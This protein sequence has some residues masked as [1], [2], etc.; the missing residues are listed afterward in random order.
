M[1]SR[2]RVQA[3]LHHGYWEDVGTIRSYYDANIALTQTQP[4][5]NF[6]DASCPIFTHPRFLAPTKIESCT[7][8]TRWS[9]MAASWP[10]P[11]SRAR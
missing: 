10:K 3:F 1:L 11:T 6:Y 4:P 5:F 8:R 2:L 9:P 7:I